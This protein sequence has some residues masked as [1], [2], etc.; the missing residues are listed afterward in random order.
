MTDR[1]VA[2]LLAE[3]PEIYA[4]L[5]AVLT[6]RTPGGEEARHA[7]PSPC[8]PMRLE[9]AALLDRRVRLDGDALEMADWDT[10]AGEDR[11]GLL[12]SLWAWGRLIEAEMLD[13][14]PDLPEFLPDEP[15]MASVCA[16][17]VRYTPWA[18]VQ[19]WADEY[20]ADIRRRHGAAERLVRHC[21]HYRAHACSRCGGDSAE[22]VNNGDLWACPDCGHADPGPRREIDAFRRRPSMPTPMVCALMGCTQ[23]WLWQQHHRGR[24]QPDS[25]KGSRPLWWWPWDI[26]SLLNPAIV[27]EW[28]SSQGIAVLS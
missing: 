14:S 26:F 27:D 18:L 10:A 11:Q 6:S 2:E 21:D 5:P 19:P 24:I 4:L 28:E 23:E 22:L 12:P 8:A 15:T 13:T 16:W 25:A 3:L 20:T 1:P 17:L 9:V 7:R